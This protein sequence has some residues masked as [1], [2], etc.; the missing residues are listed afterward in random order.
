MFDVY[1]E[2]YD[3]THAVMPFKWLHSQML[4]SVS[5]ENGRA[6]VGAKRQLNMWQW[7]HVMIE[8]VFYFVILQN[9][10]N[11]R[12]VAC[13]VAVIESIQANNGFCLFPLFLLF[14]ASHRFTVVNDTPIRLA[15]SS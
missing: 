3:G 8:S 15:N 11:L 13:V 6:F 12:I 4:L 9:M 1:G 2:F 10:K 7:Y 5:F 14:P